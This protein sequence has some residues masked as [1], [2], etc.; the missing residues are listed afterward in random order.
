L[1]SFLIKLSSEIISLDRFRICYVGKEQMEH[2]FF[3]KA[4]LATA[5]A[6][7]SSTTLLTGCLVD[8]DRSNA[9]STT[10]TEASL[11]NNYQRVANPIGTVAGF[12]QDIQGNPIAG[13]TVSIAGRTTTTTVGG[14]YQ[15][16][17]I[18]VT[19]VV[20]NTTHSNNGNETNDV[21]GET[22]QVLLVSI[23]PPAG[24]L[25]A[26]VTVTA[27]S[28][29]V[30]Y[31]GN[32][33][34]TNNSTGTLTCATDIN[35]HSFI[36]GFIAQAGT[37]VL[38]ALNATVTGTL[39]DDDTG[40]A[41]ANTEVTL[42]MIGTYLTS[43]SLEDS[44]LLVNTQNG[45]E[46]SY[47]VGNVV[48]TTDAEGRFTFTNVPSKSALRPRV[49]GYTLAS[50]QENSANVP[51]ADAISTADWTSAIE[52]GVVSFERIIP[53]ADNDAP[54]V[55]R[56]DSVTNG[57]PGLFNDDIDLTSAGTGLV[58]HFSEPLAD[59][60]DAT[61][62]ENSVEVLVWNDTGA[63]AGDGKYD[64]DEF[65]SGA[66]AVI[67]TV[68]LSADRT[69]M[70]L[71]LTTDITEGQS[72]HVN[73]L[74]IDFTDIA[75][76]QLTDASAINYDDTI[77]GGSQNN[78]DFVRLEMST[79]VDINKGAVA[80]TSAQGTEDT[81][82]IDTYQALTAKNSV[83]SDV[84][85]G[86][87]LISHL[88]A[89]DDDGVGAADV[90]AR[91]NALQAAIGGGAAGVDGDQAIITFTPNTA[92][93]YIISVQDELGADQTDYSDITAVTAN[94]I[95][96]NGSNVLT[97][98]DGSTITLSDANDVSLVLN[99][100]EAGW[101]VSII[102]VDDLGYGFGVP[103]STTLA[104]LVPP[105]TVLQ[106][107]YGVANTSDYLV[108]GETFGDG[109]ELANAGNATGQTPILNITAQLLDN[110][111]A[112]GTATVLTAN[113]DN[114]LAKELTAKNAVNP[115]T[116]APYITTG[117]DNTAYAAM[118]AAASASRTMG[119]AFSEDIAHVTDPAFAGTAVLN[120]WTVA[121]DV[122]QDDRGNAHNV[123]LM[124]FD[125]NNVFTLAADNGTAIDFTDDVTD[126]AT[127]PNAAVASTNPRVIVRDAL[128]P[129]IVSGTYNG[130]SVT[131]TFN[132]KVVPKNGDV[133]NFTG[134]FATLSVFPD[135]GDLSAEN[136]SLD[137]TG[138]VLT[139][140]KLA[141]GD[142]LPL[143]TA[144]AL[145]GAGTNMRG[146]FTFNDIEDEN[147]NNWTDDA[148]GITPIIPYALL[149]GVNRTMSVTAATTSGGAGSASIVL[150]AT[151]PHRVAT[152]TGTL[153]QAEITALVT[154]TDDAGTA[155]AVDF[156]AASG[157]VSTDGRTITLTLP[158]VGGTLFNTGDDVQVTFSSDWDSTQTNLSDNVVM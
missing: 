145:N 58:V 134:G 59:S 10:T 139:I 27:P 38:P 52:V 154:Y 69:S 54:Y 115:T 75:G 33:D 126:T 96:S 89:T 101:A 110:L 19:D 155:N 157:T 151:T 99:N 137:G 107:S 17:N 82:G 128:P 88:N 9:N 8:G 85:D 152:Y 130:D 109:G 106:T 48:T 28:A 97:G 95:E 6:L 37:A 113:D 43:G 146:L 121:N 77:S 143:T 148:Y 100:V 118:S 53:D 74:T 140:D 108:T 39:R 64:Q 61:T 45:T 42:E 92:S 125:V 36:D 67:N 78:G 112:D 158:T 105:T 131:L 55:T 87:T 51:G 35:T 15:F 23:T 41:L 7:V 153:T 4:K 29:V 68:V 66:Y 81:T 34:C 26:T 70:T 20:V 30:E 132:E 133:F 136:Y 60:V 31:G 127:T 11:S 63:S 120:N 117:Y 25:G 1:F 94:V 84:K 93:G 122:L 144:F 3:Q 138:T 80:V 142:N 90:S 103:T 86:D 44:V 46:I 22:N 123:D 47:A 149:A 135:N 5:I 111:S 18:P 12:V 72:V 49:A 141:W 62:L 73:L 32:D 114:S 150:S 24:Y 57:N 21:L 14:T 119:V 13:A 65:G 76:N 83:F 91:L 71:T 79:F 104:D 16:T 156:A 124:T 98:S 2:K 116:G 129:F 50:V 56:V 102:P 40:V 147:E